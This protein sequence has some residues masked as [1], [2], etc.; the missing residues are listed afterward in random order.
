MDEL[1][2]LHHQLLLRF[3]VSIVSTRSLIG[4]EIL[5]LDLTSTTGQSGTCHYL[6]FLDGIGKITPTLTLL[7]L[8]QGINSSTD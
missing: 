3:V 2:L 6:S 1:L 7:L 8:N 5:L 4:C